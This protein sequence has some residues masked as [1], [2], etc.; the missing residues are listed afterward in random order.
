MVDDM[1][2]ARVAGVVVALAVVLGG[3]AAVDAVRSEGAGDATPGAATS[4]SSTSAPAQPA[5]DGSTRTPAVNIPERLVD[6]ASW[7][8]REGETALEVDPADRLR[9]AVDPR[10]HEEAWQ[11]ILA[12]VPD[13]DT[14]G[15]REQFLCHA[16]FASDKDA[17]FLE[18]RRPD[19]GY[20][21][22]VRAGCNPGDVV[23]V[24]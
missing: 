3:W 24:G 12:A 10:V 23:D 9:Q 14:P 4:E 16:A 22:T 20:W 2:G 8:E 7:V 1:S 15:M 18:P 5:G 19:V 11:R 6:D 21:E 17:W 13:A